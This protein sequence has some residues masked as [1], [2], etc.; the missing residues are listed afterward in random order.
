MSEKTKVTIVSPDGLKKEFE[1]DTVLCFTVDKGEEFLGGKAKVIEAN[2]CYVGVDIPEPIFAKTIGS[3]VGAFI[4]HRSR[5]D[6]AKA[7]YNLNEVS[8]ILEA[9]SRGLIKDVPR[10]QL[11][12]ELHEA[13][14]TFLKVF[15]GR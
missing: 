12:K 1:A 4:E 3:L 8:V 13:V 2:E 10:E 9:K 11:E 5:G 7:A 15:S 14:E 6:A